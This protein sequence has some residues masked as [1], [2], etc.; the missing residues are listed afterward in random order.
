MR[1][2]HITSGLGAGG[3]ERSLLQLVNASEPP[4]SQPVATHMRV[5]SL[6]TAAALAP[7]FSCPP[8]VFDLKGERFGA[9]SRLLTFTRRFKPDVI[10]GWMYH[11]NLAASYLGWRMGAPVIW[12]I[13]HSLARPEAEAAG[14]RWVVRLG[15]MACYQPKRVVYNSFSGWRTHAHFGYGP[16]P[17]MI[18]PNGVDINYFSTSANSLAPPIESAACAVPTSEPVIGC[19]ARFH[20]MKGLKTLLTAHASLQSTTACQLVLAGEGMDEHN[21]ELT[22]MID[23]VGCADKTTRLGFVSDMRN[24]YR[25][26]SVLVLPSLFGE[27]T[28]NAVLEAMAAGIPAI[29]TR[30]GDAPRCIDR[31]EWLVEPGDAG[32][33]S[34]KL[35]QMFALDTAQRAALIAGNTQ[36]LQANYSLERCHERYHALYQELSGQFPTPASAEVAS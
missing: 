1:V 25:Q 7:Q 5:A 16:K 32:E 2:L 18:I 29:A 35:G 24:L 21:S 26:F 23:Q 17:S 14:L 31:Q 8:V 36:H 11:G 33:L 10:Q 30:V 9:L 22:T 20:P 27:G 19:V 28:P 13:R 6:T 34:D 15:R 4:G 3:A 12:S